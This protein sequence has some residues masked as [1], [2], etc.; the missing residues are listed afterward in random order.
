MFFS[1]RLAA[2]TLSAL[3]ISH[4]FGRAIPLVKRFVPF[5]NKSVNVLAFLLSFYLL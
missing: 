2:L 5:L 3:F 1:L 4:V